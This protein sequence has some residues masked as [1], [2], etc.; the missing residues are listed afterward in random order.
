MPLLEDVAE[1]LEDATIGTVGTDIFIN[2]MP[3]GV[4]NCISLHATRGK[5]PEIVWDAEFPG[6]FIRVRNTD[7]AASNAKANDVMMALHKLTN[8]TMEITPYYFITADGSPEGLGMDDKKR[9]IYTV[10][11][12]VIKKR[13]A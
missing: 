4:D 3:D 12:S 9:Y 7:P 13:E 2:Q 11:F 5:P 10:Q 6:L 1:Y 8:V